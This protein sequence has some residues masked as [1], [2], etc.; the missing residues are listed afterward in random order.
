MGDNSP[1][2]L[3]GR[4]FQEKV[5]IYFHIHVAQYICFSFSQNHILLKTMFM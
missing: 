5:N 2:E 4:T 3:A 1:A